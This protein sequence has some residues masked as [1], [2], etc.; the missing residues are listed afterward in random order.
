MSRWLQRRKFELTER[1]IGDGE[2][3]STRTARPSTHNDACAC[4]IR[5]VVSTST[6]G[7]LPHEGGTII[8]SAVLAVIPVA[9]FIVAAMAAI[10]VAVATLTTKAHR[11]LRE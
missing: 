6:E 10:A 11:V 5:T 4:S 9:A 2:D 3:P 7:Q 8:S 1:S